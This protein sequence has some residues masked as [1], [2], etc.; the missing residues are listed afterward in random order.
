MIYKISYGPYGK[1]SFFTLSTF[2]FSFD[3]NGTSDTYQ[4]NYAHRL[5]QIGVMNNKFYVVGRIEY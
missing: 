5:T 4:S 2:I 3:N 1:I